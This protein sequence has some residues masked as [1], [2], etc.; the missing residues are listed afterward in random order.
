MGFHV[1]RIDGVAARHIEAVVLGAAEGEIGAAFRQPDES[2]RLA[3]GIE[4]HDAIKVFGLALELVDLAAANFSGFRLQAAVVA[5]AAPQIAV[6]IDPEAVER[7][8]VGGV[9]QLG[10]AAERAVGVDIIT[11]DAA[12]GR[13][14]PLDDVEL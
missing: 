4:H 1:K 3:L 12:V 14:L 11:P 5:P 7:A 9:D 10:P 13:A 8:L 6:A 2:E